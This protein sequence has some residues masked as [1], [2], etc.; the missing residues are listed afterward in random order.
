MTVKSW[1]Q[2]PFAVL[3]LL[4]ALGSICLGQESTDKEDLKSVVTAPPNSR[5]R[6]STLGGSYFVDETILQRYEA[7]LLNFAV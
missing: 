4:I 2:F 3:L 7:A 1:C 5:E 6:G